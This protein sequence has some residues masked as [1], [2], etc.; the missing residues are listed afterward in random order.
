MAHEINQ[1]LTYINTF[2]Q[3][4][5]EDV[6]LEDLDPDQIKPR[7]SEALRQVA[8]IDAIVQHLRTFGRRGDTD[9][10]R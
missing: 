4:L 8:R 1:P 3:A 5:Q 9:L 7:L 10:S 6:E 2:I